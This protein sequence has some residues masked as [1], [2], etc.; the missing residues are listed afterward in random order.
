MNN[1]QKEAFADLLTRIGIFHPKTQDS[2]INIA[3]FLELKKGETLI[4]AGAMPDK[5]WIISSGLVR[6]FY[7]LEDGRERNKAFYTENKFIGPVST[8]FSGSPS[9]FT[10][11]TLEKTHLFALSIK[12]FQAL[13]ESDNEL[14]SA[15]FKLLTDA[16]IRNEKREAM[17]LSATAED[18]YNWLLKHEP[19]WIDRVQQFHLASYLG[20]DAVSFSHLKKQRN[21]P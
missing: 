10:I 17:L 7:S 11:E 2:L 21:Q 20:I 3:S 16:F 5:F 9:P 18:R 1:V 6:H 19:Q 14:L 4:Q 12:P 13:L 15:C 8:G